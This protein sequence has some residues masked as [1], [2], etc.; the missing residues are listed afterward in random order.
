MRSRFI[1]FYL[2]HAV[3]LAVGL[4]WSCNPDSECKD[5]DYG[6]QFLLDS[7]VSPFP[8]EYGDTLFF[9]EASGQELRMKMTQ[10]LHKDLV[11]WFDISQD[12]E[13]GVCAGE[14]KINTRIE[15][16]IVNFSADSLDY[17]VISHYF[18]NSKIVDNKPI[19]YD[20]INA[21]ISNKSNTSWRIGTGHKTD[22]RGNDVHFMDTTFSYT[23]EEHKIL[24][25]KE[26]YN[27][28]SN[29]D[30]DGSEIHFN[31]EFGVVAFRERNNPLWV[32]DRI[33]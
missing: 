30:P 23:F 21:S 18:V 19:Y 14:L 33:E 15:N 4:T 20:V 28:Y 9:K 1:R 13:E 31:H 5:I 12:V 25:T 32:L 26:F 8:Y 29:T 3:A 16:K 6:T 22:Y 17:Y 2:F 11:Y 24:G 10:P 7:I 27:V